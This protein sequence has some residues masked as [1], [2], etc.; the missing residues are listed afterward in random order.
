[1]NTLP[2][3]SYKVSGLAR[4]PWLTFIPGIGN[5]ASFWDAQA[6]ALGERF[7][8]LQFDPW[9]HA[10]SPAPPPG[11]RFEDVVRG[12]VQLWDALGIGRS[13][14]AG[15]GFG[16]SVALAL[17]L[18]HPD[19]VEQVVAC[20][21]RPRQP[22]DRRDFWRARRAA[23]GLGMAPLVEATVDRWLG[24]D[25]R[26]AHPEVDARLR[27]MMRRTT[28]AGYQAALDAFIDMDFEDAL[29]K[30]EVPV[31]LVAAEHDHGGG[32]VQAMRAMAQRIPG[33]RLAI[34]PDSG[35]ICNHEAPEALNAILAGFLGEPALAR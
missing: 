7:R 15:L 13:A 18:G 14:V 32:P 24:A 26:A 8:I 21:C 29:E 31:L 30:I 2:S 3:L 10:A 9:G 5:D 1:M 19:R 17:G 27:A 22:D 20:C 6:A 28:L 34:V 23:A 11:C 4:A 35:H 33:A 16:G 25:F 12:V